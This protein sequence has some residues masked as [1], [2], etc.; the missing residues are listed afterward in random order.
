MGGPGRLIVFEGTEGVGKSTQAARLHADLPGSVLVRE[1]GGTRLGEQLRELVL[2]SGGE[3]E[4]R[5]ELLIF[6]AARAQLVPIIRQHLTEGTPVVADRFF[7]STYA[8]QGAGRGLPENEIREANRVATDGLVPDLTFVLRYP[9]D[10]GLA[11][12]G[13]RD[14]M[15]RS[16]VEFHR[17]VAAAFD[18]FVT[19]DWQ[20]GH[21]ECGQI[22]D[23]D[24]Q[25]GVDEVATRV[26]LALSRQWPEVD[27]WGEHCGHG[28]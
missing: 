24:A 17:R 1:P 5:A 13:G 15:E 4:P 23:V 8:Y 18:R 28:R 27:T 3:I 12:A 11:R 16:G 2:H 21:S 9:V 6:L 22:V 7:L 14:R 26:R 10:A 20:A 19:A 25:G